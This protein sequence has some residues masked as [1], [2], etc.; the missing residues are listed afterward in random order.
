M[1][2]VS[3]QENCFKEFDVCPWV[4]LGQDESAYHVQSSVYKDL[5]A[6]LPRELM[7]YSD[8]PF[9]ELEWR[10]MSTDPRKFPGHFEVGFQA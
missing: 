1:V 9:A 2:H 8:F 7:A 5:R 3:I 4:F 10:G 6:N